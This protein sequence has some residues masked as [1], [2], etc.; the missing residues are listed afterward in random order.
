M[1]EQI[2]LIEEVDRALLRIDK[3]DAFLT[4]LESLLKNNSKPA[5]CKHNSDTGVCEG[6]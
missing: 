3:T 5:S 1:T 4:K 6:V 2:S